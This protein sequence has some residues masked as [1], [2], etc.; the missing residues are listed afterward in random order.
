MLTSTSPLSSPVTSLPWLFEETVRL[1]GSCRLPFL[2][3]RKNAVIKMFLYIHGE[4]PWAGLPAPNPGSGLAA[5]LAG[6]RPAAWP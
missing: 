3:G 1:S 2:A 5:R 4:P 6:S